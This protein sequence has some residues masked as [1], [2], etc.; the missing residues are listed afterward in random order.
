MRD[1]YDPRDL[2]GP[3]LVAAL[4]A[5]LRLPALCAF[6]ESVGFLLMLIGALL[7]DGRLLL[8]MADALQ[9]LGDP[10]LP[11]FALVARFPSWRK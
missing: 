4:R 10:R 1:G 11:F 5:P 7:V 8:M 6:R 3:G 9:D 2:F